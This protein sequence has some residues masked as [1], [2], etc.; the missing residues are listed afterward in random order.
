MN[1]EKTIYSVIVSHEASIYENH[2]YTSLEEARAKVE[3]VLQYWKSRKHCT[4]RPLSVHPLFECGD[5]ELAEKAWGHQY[6]SQEGWWY[7]D[8]EWDY[9]SVVLMECTLD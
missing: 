7:E 2:L 9:G 6:A 1:M 4:S 5:R 8:G 3:E